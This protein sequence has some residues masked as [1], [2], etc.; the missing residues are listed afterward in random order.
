MTSIQKDRDPILDQKFFELLFPL[1]F[2]DIAMGNDIYNF[3]KNRLSKEDNLL[4]TGSLLEKAISV[5]KKITRHATIGKDF[6]DGSDAKSSSCRWYSKN[7]AYGAPISDIS[8]KRGLLRAVVYERLHDTFYFFLIPYAAYK[9]IP[10]TSNIEI[11][12]NLDGSP[13]R[14]S[15][16]I[17]NVDWWQFQVADFNGILADTANSFEFAKDKK[18]RISQEKLEKLVSWREA[19]L[20]S[21]SIVSPNLDSAQLTKTDPIVKTPSLCS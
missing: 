10:K 5:Q 3:C 16:A 18:L 6:V 2:P 1:A 9:N 19:R 12:F 14:D 8:N 20:S 13:R 11:P 4:S 21:Q 7:T 17:R 15:K